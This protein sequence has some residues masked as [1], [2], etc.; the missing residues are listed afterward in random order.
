MLNPYGWLSWFF[1]RVLSLE[2]APDWKQPPIIGPGQ[3]RQ[4]RNRFYSG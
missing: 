2:N 3:G 1:W 4:W